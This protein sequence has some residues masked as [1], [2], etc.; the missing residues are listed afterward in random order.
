VAFVDLFAKMIARPTLQIRNRLGHEDG[1]Q[2]TTKLF[3]LTH[4]VWG[5]IPSSRLYFSLPYFATPP[6][7]TLIL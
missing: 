6:S 3:G 4:V 1:K 5:L 7:N 2:R